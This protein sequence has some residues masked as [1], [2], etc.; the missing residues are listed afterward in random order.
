MARTDSPPVNQVTKGAVL[1]KFACI[2]PEASVW[3]FTSAGALTDGTSGD[4]AGWAG[5]GSICIR[6][7]TM[8]I[9]INGGTKASPAYKL[10]TSA[11]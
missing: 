9:Y 6:L 4:G 11:A 1:F 10:V 7:D 5:P 3:L 2:D 8:K